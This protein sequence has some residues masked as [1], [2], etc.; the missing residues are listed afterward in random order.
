M[1]EAAAKMAAI[2]STGIRSGK[3]AT[4]S[5]MTTRPPIAN[6]S[7]QALAAAMAPKSDGSS[8]SGGKKSVVDTTAVSSLTRYTAASSN[9][10]KP[11]SKSATGA[12]RA[13][14]RTNPDNG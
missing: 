10:A 14:S 13:R 11:T 9:G 1:A 3:A 4:Y 8:T 2:A 7:E 5:A 12:A 6:T